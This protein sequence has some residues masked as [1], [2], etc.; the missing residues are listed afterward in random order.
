MDSHLLMSMSG[1]FSTYGIHLFYLLINLLMSRHLIMTWLGMCITSWL[2]QL[3]RTNV[4]QPCGLLSVPPPLWI[5]PI[6]S[7]I[8]ST[9]ITLALSIARISLA[10]SRRISSSAYD[11][12]LTNF[13]PFR[14]HPCFEKEAHVRTSYLPWRRCRAANSHHRSPLVSCRRAVISQPPLSWPV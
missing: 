6:V 12:V 11:I 8:S 10:H 7:F 2:V 1:W 3:S 14:E 5:S 4:H 13:S 9:V